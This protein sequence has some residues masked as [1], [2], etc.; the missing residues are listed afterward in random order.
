MRTNATVGYPPDS[1]SLYSFTTNPTSSPTDINDFM[2]FI[3]ASLQNITYERTL[4]IQVQLCN[5]L[6]YLLGESWLSRRISW[7]HLHFQSNDLS[8]HGF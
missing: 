8:Y 3:L 4:F 1:F 7:L 5:A 6:G 2:R